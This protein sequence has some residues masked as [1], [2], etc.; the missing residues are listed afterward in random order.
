MK[1]LFVVGIVL[2][3]AAAAGLLVSLSANIVAE[4][5]KAK[6]V[7]KS[8][9]LTPDAKRKS[10]SIVFLGNVRVPADKGLAQVRQSIPINDPPGIAVNDDGG[11]QDPG[12]KKPVKK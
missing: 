12:G 2:S 4:N 11:P 5:A 10:A 3:M 6:S 7:D 9:P 8:L 1:R